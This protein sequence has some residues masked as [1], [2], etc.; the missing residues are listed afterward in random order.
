M[1]YIELGLVVA[2][3]YVSKFQQPRN[4]NDYTADANKPSTTRPPQ[5]V[6]NHMALFLKSFCRVFHTNHCLNTGPG[7]DTINGCRAND[8]QTTTYSFK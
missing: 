2:F 7:N 4:D 6:G 8:P 1:R 5:N 3:Q